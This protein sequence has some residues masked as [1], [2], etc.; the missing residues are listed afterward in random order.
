MFSLHE[1]LS[2]EPLSWVEM[3]SLKVKMK[4][5]TSDHPKSEGCV[6]SSFLLLLHM[7]LSSI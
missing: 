2:R 7:V 6:V 4:E 3:V 1:L 5:V